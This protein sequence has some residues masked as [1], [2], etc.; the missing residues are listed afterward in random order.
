M[1]ARVPVATAPVICRLT[2]VLL[3]VPG[4]PRT[5]WPGLVTSPARS[6]ASGS[7]Q[8]TSPH[9]WC[10]PTGVPATGVPL[11]ATNGD[12]P[13][14]WVVVASY[15]RP[16]VTC[17]ARP[18]S[19]SFHPQAGATGTGLPARCGAVCRPS[20]RTAPTDG[21]LAE[22]CCREGG[23][24]APNSAGGRGAAD[25]PGDPEPAAPPGVPDTD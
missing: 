18:P 25:P 13:D 14:S 11:P 16:G 12:S 19:R 22:G 24:E 7:R 1:M 3:P 4:W 10:R 9:S 15:S 23:A 6:Q 21:C 17:T 5:N 8:T 20:A 2:R